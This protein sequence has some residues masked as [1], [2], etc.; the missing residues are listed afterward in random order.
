MIHA[1]EAYEHEGRMARKA[2]DEKDAPRA[3]F[4]FQAARRMI[5]M[6]D[7]TADRA[8]AQRYVD[9]AYRNRA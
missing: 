1:I 2:H 9:D 3:S 5:A 8:L 7:G 4:H 6:E